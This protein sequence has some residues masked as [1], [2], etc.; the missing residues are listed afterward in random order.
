ME[1][2]KAL[3]LVLSCLLFMMQLFPITE[4]NAY[5]HMMLQRRDNVRNLSQFYQ[6]LQSQPD[7]DLKSDALNYKQL[8][9]RSKLEKKFL[10]S[11]EYLLRLRKKMNMYISEDKKDKIGSSQIKCR[12]KENFKASLKLSEE[13]L[14]KKIDSFYFFVAKKDMYMSWHSIYDQRRCVY[15]HM[16]EKIWD[17]CVAFTEKKNIPKNVL[18]KVWWKAYADLI[19]ELE[20][21]DSTSL[22][23]FYDLYFRD[24]C[25][26]CN[27]IQLLNEN[28][29][30]WRDITTKMKN[31][32][33]NELL[34]ELKNY[35]Q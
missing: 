20:I 15:I 13:E 23:K 17:K 6:P 22:C 11:N 19:G 29:K 10:N 32:W 31:K 5:F 3:P 26:R 34:R 30:G 7:T 9:V 27:F 2:L 8:A 24:K 33:K 14:K 21:F 12:S 16:M 25:A 28:K 18:F 4:G 1:P 35:T